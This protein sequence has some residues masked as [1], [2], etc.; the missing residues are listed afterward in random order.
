MHAF[1]SLRDM[2]QPFLSELTSSIINE[3]KATFPGCSATEAA[4]PLAVQQF[5]MQQ[6]GGQG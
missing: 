6:P 1:I 3:A 4:D 5:T 2:V